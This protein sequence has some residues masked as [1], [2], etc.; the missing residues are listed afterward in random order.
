MAAAGGS[1][2]GGK[3]VPK[4]GGNMFER[5]ELPPSSSSDFN[6]ERFNAQLEETLRLRSALNKHG[7]LSNIGFNDPAQMR[8]RGQ[9]RDAERIGRLQTLTNMVQTDYSND[10]SKFI[11]D[12]K[13]TDTPRLE[14]LRDALPSGGAKSAIIMVLANRRLKR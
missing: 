14:L 3:F 7:M 10:K 12:L 4:D 8:A 13:G 2:K 1:W 6:A 11:R 9:N 5:G